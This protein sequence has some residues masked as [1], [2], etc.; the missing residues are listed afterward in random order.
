MPVIVIRLFRHAAKSFPL[1]VA[2]SAVATLVGVA[3]ASSRLT[4]PRRRRAHATEVA[5]LAKLP[6]AEVVAETRRLLEGWKD[7][8]AC[9][10]LLAGDTIQSHADLLRA[11]RALFAELDAADVRDNSSGR[12]SRIF[13]AHDIGLTTI[14]EAVEHRLRAAPDR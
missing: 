2:L 12:S 6:L 1:L 8:P 7:F 11:L 10:A 13:E 9:Q 3:L 5:R 14:A 4:A